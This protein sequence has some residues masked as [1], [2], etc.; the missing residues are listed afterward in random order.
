MIL[1][2]IDSGDF[3]KVAGV[4]FAESSPEL[5]AASLRCA[6]DAADGTIQVRIDGIEGELLASLPVKN[7]TERQEFAE[8]RTALLTSVQGVHDLYLIF[9]GAG[10]EVK[11]W[12]F[13]KKQ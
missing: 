3:I 12:R 7:L 2:R 4:D 6:E 8:C 1:T 10:Y 5:F 11:S 9:D 13:A